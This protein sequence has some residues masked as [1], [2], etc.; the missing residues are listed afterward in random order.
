[1]KKRGDYWKRIPKK[2]RSMRMSLIRKIG[3]AKKS[4]E[5]RRKWSKLMNEK[6]WGNNL[7]RHIP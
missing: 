4:K 3:W 7:S 2:E 6:R 1:M 5:E